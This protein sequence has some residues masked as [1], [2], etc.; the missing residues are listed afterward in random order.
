[1]SEFDWD[2]CK[3]CTGWLSLSAKLSDEQGEEVERTADLRS[4][5]VIHCLYFAFAW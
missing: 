3:Y 2:L 5:D 4:E 1:M